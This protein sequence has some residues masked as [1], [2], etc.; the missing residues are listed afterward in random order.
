MKN[1]FKKGLIL[2]GLLAVGATVG[3]VMSKEGK[4]LS[5]ELEKDFKFLAKQ[6]KRDLHKLE[7][8]TKENFDKLVITVV[9]GYAKKEVIVSDNKRS[10][11]KTLQEKWQEM[12][13]EYLAEKDEEKIKN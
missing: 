8:V 4:K 5:I 12:E 3:F 10:L 6:L 7:D 13:K 11:I 9:E 2:G 1:K